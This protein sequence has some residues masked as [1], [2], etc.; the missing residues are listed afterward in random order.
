MSL[1][2]PLSDRE[3]DELDRFLLSDRC[4]DECMTLDALHGFVTAL[5]LGPEQ[6]SLAE[7]L[8]RVWGPAPE[9]APQF[10]SAQ[11]MDRI[12]GL[13]ARFANEIS[14]TF[15]V[16]PKEFEPLFS[17]FEENGQ[18]YID[19]EPWAW[20]F[21]EAMQLRAEAWQAAWEAPEMA[22]LLRPI[23]L[24]GAEEVEE[25]DLQKVDTPAKVHRLSIEIEAALPAIRR[26]WQGKRKSIEPVK[27]EEPK[28]GRNDLCPCGSGKKFKKC[29][30]AH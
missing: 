23:E 27:R 2:T 12:T 28:S 16:A 13:I 3:F 18:T 26:Y 24:L 15:E 30:G 19:G 5:V 22:P 11:E 29:C 14:I 25:E 10:R 8:P 9:D 6:V 17:Q 4:S 20:G 1:D 7:W 21:W